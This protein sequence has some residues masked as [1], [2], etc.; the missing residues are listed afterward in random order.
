LFGLSST[1]SVKGLLAGDCGVMG[2]HGR[3]GFMVT[4]TVTNRAGRWANEGALRDQRSPLGWKDVRLVLHGRPQLY[5]SRDD[6]AEERA[7]YVLRR[8]ARDGSFD[9]ATEC[10]LGDRS[11]QQS[12]D[13]PWI[14]RNDDAALEIPPRSYARLPRAHRLTSGRYPIH[15]E[16][17]ARRRLCRVR[18]ARRAA[19]FRTCGPFVCAA[20]R[21]AALLAPGDRRRAAPL[22]CRDSALRDAAPRVS[23][24]SAPVIARDRVRD[25]RLRPRRAARV[26]YSALRFVF[27]FALAGGRGSFT[28]ARRAF[29]SPMAMACLVERAPCLPRRMCSISSRTNS[30]ACVVGALLGS[31]GGTRDENRVAVRR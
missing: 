29:E 16:A 4:S 30:P 23:R 19:A 15:A 21:A 27:A 20:R 2:S 13:P 24:F 12:R 28:P 10:R 8:R 3:F 25:G 17:T 14:T 11:H 5:A 9:E 26:A 18:A 1:R 7:R 6:V 22:A 31:V